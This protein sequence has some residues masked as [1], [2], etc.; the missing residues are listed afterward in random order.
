[1][2]HRVAGKEMQRCKCWGW[3]AVPRWWTEA[4]VSRR[5][6]RRSAVR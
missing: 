4:W 5:G 2:M 6:V 3:S 1:M